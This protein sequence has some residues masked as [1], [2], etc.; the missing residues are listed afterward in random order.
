MNALAERTK[1]RTKA[2]N[3]AY[4]NDFQSFMAT[5]K[6]RGDQFVRSALVRRLDRVQPGVLAPVAIDDLWEHLQHFLVQHVFAE[7]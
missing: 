7:V 3:V 5:V 1:A 4:T 2:A 6:L